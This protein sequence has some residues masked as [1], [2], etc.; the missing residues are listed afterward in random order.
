MGGQSIPR[1]KQC[2]RICLDGSVAQ[3]TEVWVRHVRLAVVGLQ[4]QSHNSRSP[5]VTLGVRDVSPALDLF[6]KRGIN[7]KAV[8]GTF[9]DYRTPKSAHER[10][11]GGMDQMGRDSGGRWL[12]NGIN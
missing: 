7:P 11:L 5:A 12:R 6:A 1:S 8:R 10:G 9:F 3:K 2:K 4:N